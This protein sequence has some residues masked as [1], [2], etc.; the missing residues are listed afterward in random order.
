MNNE[1]ISGP[2][3]AGKVGNNKYGK[4]WLLPLIFIFGLMITLPYLNGFNF[5]VEYVLLNIFAFLACCLL[6]TRLGPPLVKK[7]PIWI[8]FLYLLL[9]YFL[10]FYLLLVLPLDIPFTGAELLHHSD[11]LT[12]DVFRTTTYAFVAF[13]ITSWLVLN[14][15]S[16]SSSN[17]K[18]LKSI[19]Y[20]SLASFL[21]ITVPF[22]MIVTGLLMYK[23]NIKMGTNEYLPFRLLGWTAYSR[24][25]L[26]PSLLLL[27][28]YISQNTNQTRNVNWG[29]GLLFMHGFSEVLLKTSRG[30]LISILFMITTLIIITSQMNKKHLRMIISVML[31]VA[32]LFPVIGIFRNIR[33]ANP[34]IVSSL[35]ETLYLSNELF[36]QSELIGI[37]VLSFF[38]RFVGTDY[39]TYVINANF[40]NL[41]YEL[42]TGVV[43]ES[44]LMKLAVGIPV[45]QATGISPGLIGMLYL[46]G[47]LYFTIIG[48]SIF[49]MAV[50]IV[51]RLVSGLK[52]YTVPIAQVLFLF[53]LITILSEG[54]FRSVH[55]QT[56]VIAGS[57]AAC[58]CLT[59]SYRQVK[60]YNYNSLVPFKEGPS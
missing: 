15:P 42:F 26:I 21:K 53:Q 3:K 58:E 14:P 8:I 2:K 45:W 49:T 6:L 50:W 28:I 31:F 35:D 48:T 32:V 25:I 22:L 51:W 52:I 47:G 18:Q 17:S 54:I 37:E 7:L 9:F 36:S 23:Y 13:C 24:S 41:Y 59:R 39:L 38:S 5:M 56:I 46:N 30:A 44:E 55:L 1:V 43:T 16:I 33:A 12:V 10:K 20:K 19:R 4:R 34:S 27:L 29:I 57:V 11:E 40:G 60:D